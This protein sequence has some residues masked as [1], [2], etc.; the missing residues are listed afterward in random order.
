MKWQFLSLI[1]VVVAAMLVV[2]R[3]SGKKSGG[4]GCNCG[5]AHDLDSGPKKEKAVR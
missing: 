2:W 4:C 1:V 3:S 5:C